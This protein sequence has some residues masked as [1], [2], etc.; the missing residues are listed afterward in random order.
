MGSEWA[1]S[2]LE[3]LSSTISYGYT[4]SASLKKVGPHFLRITDI[5]KGTVD[6]EKV[7]YCP[8]SENDHQKYKLQDGDIVVARTGNSTGENYIFSGI[9][10]AVFASYLI[11]FRLD[12]TKSYSK[13]VWYS[14][15]S[16]QWWE[17]INGAKTGSA[18][19]GANAKVLGRY[20]VLI[21]PLPEQKAI[22]H[23]LGSLDDKIELNRRMNATL[24]SMAQALFKSWFVDFDPVI[25]NALVAGNP[26]PE[27]LT[28]RAEVRRKALT[29]G[30]ANRETAKQFPDAF[31]LTEELGLIPEGWEVE[32]LD[33]IADYKNGLALQKFRPKPGENPLPIVKIAQLKSGE[34]TWDE[35]ASPSIA[36]ECIINDGD[37]VFS[38]SGSLMIDLWCGG[39]AALNQ[40]LFKVTSF[41]F[42]KWFYL[43]WSNEHLLNFQKIAA[44]KAVTMGHIK[45]SHL[46]EA[47]CVIPDDKLLTRSSVIINPYIE[48][49]ISLRLQNRTLIKLR[50]TLLPKLISGELRIPEA[51]KLAKEALT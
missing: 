34:A 25:D 4:E 46:S 12:E 10:D 42:P 14:M 19:A 29:D 3:E 16:D 49:S 21:P 5:Q 38:W 36:S 22:A 43:S 39:K 33:K 51:E 18:Q 31:Q 44:D 8:I 13:Y 40:H 20:S 30:T 48:N 6:W 17:F 47:K 1:K 23:I 9:S 45:R 37:V 7:P 27:E 32:S 41:D 26:I 28:E 35:L 2:T 15:R 50:D 24:E 11:R